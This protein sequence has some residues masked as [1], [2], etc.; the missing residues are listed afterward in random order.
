MENEENKIDILV[1][2]EEDLNR[3]FKFDYE[4]QNLEKNALYIQWKNSMLSKYGKDVKLFKC[5]KDKIYFYATYNEY[6]NIYFRQAKCPI[7]KNPICYYCSRFFNDSLN[8][9]ASCCLKRKIR[10]IFLKDSFIY[11]NRERDG[12]FLYFFIPG[13]SFLFLF[14]RIQNSFFYKLAMKNAKSDE[15]GY[16]P[17]YMY[18]TEKTDFIFN[19]NFLSCILF[20]IPFFIIN[21]YIILFTF[22]ISIPFKYI[23]LKYIIGI[24]YGSFIL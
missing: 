15:N 22:I 24:A 19:I 2:N 12:Y 1:K 3:I 5:L 9:K 10:F 16:L 11:F 17:I 20:I 21:I 7:C 8:K 23:P 18:N 13:W 14:L 4:G 6:N